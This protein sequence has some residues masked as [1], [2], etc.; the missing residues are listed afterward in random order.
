MVSKLNKPDKSVLLKFFKYLN[1]ANYD[2]VCLQ[3]NQTL[4]SSLVTVKVFR[5]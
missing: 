5:I 1:T 2:M 4:I 3:E